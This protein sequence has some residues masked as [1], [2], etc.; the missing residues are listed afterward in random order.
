MKRT[1]QIACLVFLLL[2]ATMGASCPSVDESGTKAE[3]EMYYA[4]Y[5][6]VQ[7]GMRISEIE[8]IPGMTPGPWIL[9]T[10]DRME[11]EEEEKSLYAQ[12]D[13]LSAEYHSLCNSYP[14][15][16]CGVIVY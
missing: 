1:T 3:S 15:L 10:Y 9:T 5:K 4:G 13:S 11:I 12:S 6:A 8:A 14:G 7:I 16:T 2:L